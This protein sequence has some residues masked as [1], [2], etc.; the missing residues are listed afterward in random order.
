VTNSKETSAGRT[1]YAR[2]MD[3]RNTDAYWRAFLNYLAAGCT[4]REAEQRADL[5][6]F[7]RE[8]SSDGSK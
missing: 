2:R 1:P 4:N 7:M 5:E 8:C 6:C 3:F